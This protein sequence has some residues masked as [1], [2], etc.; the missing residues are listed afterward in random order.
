M[1]E[2]NRP[3]LYLSAEDLVAAMIGVGLTVEGCEGMRV[4]DWSARG[5]EGAEDG[6]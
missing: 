3:R 5:P 2:Q 4:V 1:L 6:G